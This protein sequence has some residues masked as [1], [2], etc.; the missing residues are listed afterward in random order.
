MPFHIFA[1]RPYHWNL[2]CVEGL[3]TS[4][5]ATASTVNDGYDCV[6]VDDASLQA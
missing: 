1:K 6:L 2:H 4:L 5:I 3:D